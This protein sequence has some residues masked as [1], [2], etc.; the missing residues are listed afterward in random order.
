MTKAVGSVAAGQELWIPNTGRRNANGT[1]YI[2]LP[3][4][5][6]GYYWLSDITGSYAYCFAMGSSRPTGQLIDNDKLYALPVRCV[7]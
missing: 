4:G 3:P 7:R 2:D 1:V 5:L 6:I